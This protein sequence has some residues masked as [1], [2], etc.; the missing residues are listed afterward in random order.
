VVP[1]A[2]LLERARDLLASHFARHGVV[3]RIEDGTDGGRVEVDAEQ[4]NQLLLNLLQNALAAT[5]ET[6]RRPAVAL[7]ASRLGGRIAIEVVDN[8]VGIEPADRDR[9]F[10]AFYSTRKGGTG[11]GLAVVRRIARAHGAE[12]ELDSAVG[13]GTT[14]RVV[15]PAAEPA[16]TADAPAS[17][18]AAEPVSSGSA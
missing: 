14:V 11:L 15:L 6:G 9:V 16:A 2:E 3:L 1:V 5:E 12:L 13:E 7:R 4:W 8:G 18:P 17:P 10:E